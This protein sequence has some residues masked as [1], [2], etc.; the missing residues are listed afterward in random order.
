MAVLTASV[1]RSVIA[2][3]I[4]Q[5]EVIHAFKRFLHDTEPVSPDRRKNGAQRE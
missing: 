3:S 5:D 2:I 1:N 4:F